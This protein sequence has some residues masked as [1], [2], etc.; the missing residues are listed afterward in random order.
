MSANTE[1]VEI[2]RDLKDLPASAIYLSGIL[3]IKAK[4]P[5]N[6]ISKFLHR[7]YLNYSLI[8]ED[9]SWIEHKL[10]EG[11]IGEVH[12][13]LKTKPVSTDL[14]VLVDRLKLSE[15]YSKKYPLSSE[16][17][18]FCCGEVR[19][20]Y[21]TYVL[22][23]CKHCFHKACLIT[24]FEYLLGEKISI[25]KCPFCSAKISLADLRRIL[26]PMRFE[27]YNEISYL[28]L[29]RSDH[30]IVCENY[31]CKEIFDLQRN[32]KSCMT[33]STPFRFDIS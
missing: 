24:E 14:G 25:I 5:P 11:K 33:C 10:L 17:A 9:I 30:R 21:E 28:N 23:E 26:P 13:F 32:Q 19:S 1:I 8:P 31:C 7:I 4:L 6:I 20:R 3:R 18:C 22:S 29:Q 2:L 27:K 12:E 15:T 16:K